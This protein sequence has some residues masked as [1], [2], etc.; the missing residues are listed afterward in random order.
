[1]YFLKSNAGVPAKSLCLQLMLFMG[2]LQEKN[3][4]YVDKIIN[5]L[6]GLGYGVAVEELRA[7][8][9]GVP[10]IRKR[11]FFIAVRNNINCKQRDLAGTPAFDFKKYKHVK[12]GEIEENDGYRPLTKYMMDW[13]VGFIILTSFIVSKKRSSS[14][15]SFC[16]SLNFLLTPLYLSAVLFMLL[17]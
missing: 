15:C 14:V 2:L 17:K 13:W 7:M 10:Q 11:V 8:D 6:N 5:Q 4:K 1:L 16:P 9:F 3:K 12:W